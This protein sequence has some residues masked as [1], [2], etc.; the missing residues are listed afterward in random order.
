MM[1]TRSSQMRFSCSPSS[2]P[3][4]SRSPKAPSAT[5]VTSSDFRSEEA[6]FHTKELTQKQG[7]DSYDRTGI[8]PRHVLQTRLGELSTS[9]RQNHRTAYTRTTCPLSWTT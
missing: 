7:A 2:L 5:L 1:N 8:S 9:H 6:R 4:S 3:R